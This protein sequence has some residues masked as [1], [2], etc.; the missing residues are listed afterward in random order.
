[1]WFPVFRCDRQ[2]VKGLQYSGTYAQCGMVRRRL[3]T[4]LVRLRVL[5]AFELRLRIKLRARIKSRVLRL[6]LIA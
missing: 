6:A 1:M 2:K 5:A 3:L 4:N